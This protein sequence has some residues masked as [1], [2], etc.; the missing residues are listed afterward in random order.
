MTNEETLDRL[1][2]LA[3]L[4][5]ITRARQAI[6]ALESKLVLAARVEDVSWGKIAD[7]LGRSRQAVWEK[8]RMYEP[9]ARRME[10]DLNRHAGVKARDLLGVT[11]R[12]VFDALEAESKLIP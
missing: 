5:H 3:G 6:D 4:S 10:A 8:H 12:L 9:A 7:A 1:S 2:P 11:G